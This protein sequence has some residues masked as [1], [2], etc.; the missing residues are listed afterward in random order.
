[1]ATFDVDL[2]HAMAT[3]ESGSTIAFVTHF[4]GVP[5]T[6]LKDHLY[7]MT[8]NRCRGKSKVLKNVKEAT[9]VDYI[10]N[11]QRIGHPIA[12]TQL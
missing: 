4:W 5:I 7:G 10:K 1:M 9:L 8:L 3:I 12:L 6:S 2:Q 11:M